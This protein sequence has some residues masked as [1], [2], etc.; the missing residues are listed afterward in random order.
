[1]RVLQVVGQADRLV[2]FFYCTEKP[3]WAGSRLKTHGGAIVQADEGE[4]LVLLLVLAQVSDVHCL[5][6]KRWTGES[7]A[8][9]SYTA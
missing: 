9:K 1:M 6:G 7:E 2:S 5:E 4:A 3:A 8:G